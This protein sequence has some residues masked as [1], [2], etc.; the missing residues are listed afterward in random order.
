MLGKLYFEIEYIFI[1]S[2]VLHLILVNDFEIWYEKCDKVYTNPIQTHK[3]VWYYF[4]VHSV[5]ECRNPFCPNFTV[6][7]MAVTNK[8]VHG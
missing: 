8:Y 1:N 3:I 7:E 5:K 4:Q 6:V 2:V